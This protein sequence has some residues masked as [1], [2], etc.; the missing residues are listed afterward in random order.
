LVNEGVFN[1]AA[2]A[3]ASGM[4]WDRM[5]PEDRAS[6]ARASQ[7][8][9][10]AGLFGFLEDARNAQEMPSIEF[11]PMDDTLKAAKE[12]YNEALLANAAQILT[13]RGVTDA[14][15]KIDRYSALV[16]KWDG[17]ISDGITADELG[18]LRYNEIFAKLDMSAYGQ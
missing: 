18:E 7:H 2:V 16:D 10:A 1:G 15:T 4:L 3:T 8:G 6:L 12:A 11:I 5:S 17:L 14:Q 9:I 13:D